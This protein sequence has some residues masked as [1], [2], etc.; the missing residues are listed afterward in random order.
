[1]SVNVITVL[2][3]DG[4]GHFTA[5]AQQFLDRLGLELVATGDLNN[6]GHL[7]LALRAS[8]SRMQPPS[9]PTAALSV[10]VLHGDGRGHFGS[11]HTIAS[12]PDTFPQRNGSNLLAVPRQ[13]FVDDTPARVETLRR[14]APIVRRRC[15]A[16]SLAKYHRL[17]PSPRYSQSPSCGSGSRI[18]PESG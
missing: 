10:W 7:D 3:G 2:Q 4:N 5:Q 17:S 11:R 14:R 16:I 13:P 18:S 15:K 12:P 9:H 1:M 6:D 8:P